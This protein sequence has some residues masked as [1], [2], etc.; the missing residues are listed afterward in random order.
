MRGVIKGKTTPPTGVCVDL[1]LLADELNLRRR[2][3]SGECEPLLD[4]LNLLRDG[5]EN[6]LLESIELV[7]ATPGADL[8]ET[9]K[10]ATHRLKVEC[11]VAAENE[12]EAAE[13]DT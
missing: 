12:D 8:A 10:D 2:V 11:L 1:E 6:P 9:D 13:L 3:L 4:A 5:R 7:E